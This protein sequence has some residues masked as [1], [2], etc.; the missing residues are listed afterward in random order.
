MYI[1]RKLSCLFFFKYL[2]FET[3]VLL[4][5]MMDQDFDELELYFDH[6]MDDQVE[7]EYN[8]RQIY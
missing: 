5:M 7:Q 3:M 8:H 2:S 6:A 1:K 4:L